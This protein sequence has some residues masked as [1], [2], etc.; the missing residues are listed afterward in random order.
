[1]GRTKKERFLSAHR[2]KIDP[3]TAGEF[4]VPNWHWPQ[5]SVQYINTPKFV[6]VLKSTFLP[7]VVTKSM[8]VQ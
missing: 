1:M 2:L 3:D 8:Y 4:F 6:K 7:Q 5:I